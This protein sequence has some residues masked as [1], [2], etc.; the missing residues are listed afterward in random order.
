MSTPTP[1]LFHVQ[2]KITKSSP[3]P[4]LQV[5][6]SLTKVVACPALLIIPRFL[7]CIAQ[8]IQVCSSLLSSFCY[9][10]YCWPLVRLKHIFNW[11]YVL[12][13][14]KNLISF[15]QLQRRLYRDFLYSS[16][17]SQHESLFPLERKGGGGGGSSSRVVIDQPTIRGILELY[18]AA[19]FFLSLATL[20]ALCELHYLYSCIL[21]D[22]GAARRDPR[23]PN[24]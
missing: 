12:C 4:D 21:R 15:R 5:N 24:L 20:S 7:G 3:G 19:N 23:G 14:Q 9:C 13:K 10:L 1:P 16:S 18:C 17:S 22:N 2:R 8:N 6:S 11:A